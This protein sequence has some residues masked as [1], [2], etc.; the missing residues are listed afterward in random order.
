MGGQTA[1]NCALDL[2]R[3]GVL[4]RF[5]VEMIGA[6]R[7]MV[8]RVMK[9]LQLGGYIEARGSTIV[10]RDKILLPE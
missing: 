8:S 4:E 2:A 3:E 9:D 5:G 6:S 10:L 1:L 7:E